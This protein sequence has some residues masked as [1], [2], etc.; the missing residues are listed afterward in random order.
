MTARDEV[1][2]PALPRHLAVV[3]VV[4]LPL[5][6]V[7][8]TFNPLVFAIWPLCAIALAFAAWVLAWKDRHAR[9]R[10]Q[11]S[12][13]A[14]AVIAAA[15]GYYLWAGSQWATEK[16]YAPA[17]AWSVIGTALGF[18]VAAVAY[19]LARATRREAHVLGAELMVLLTVLVPG[20]PWI[21]EGF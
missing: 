9:R 20:C 2:E 4:G 18:L 7:P 10:W 11:T 5:G 16:G 6:A 14:A 3:A 12:A 1:D 21:G 8:W 13:A 19:A 17:P 15:C